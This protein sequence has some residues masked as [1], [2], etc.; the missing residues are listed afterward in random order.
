MRGLT[1]EEHATL[2][3]IL[4]PG[5]VIDICEGGPEAAACEDLVTQG[6][7]SRT[8]EGD[9]VFFD[10]TPAGVEAVRLHA[11]LIAAQEHTHG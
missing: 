7:L 4:R 11:L 5:D 10:I 8:R 9:L 6:R 2:V 3:D 1:P